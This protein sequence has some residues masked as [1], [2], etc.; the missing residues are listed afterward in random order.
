MQGARLK[1]CM[2]G[3]CNMKWVKRIICWWRG[4]DWLI[5]PVYGEMGFRETA[6]FLYTAGHCRRCGKDT[7]D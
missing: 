5:Y 2:T 1:K 4:H 7:E 3:R 6:D